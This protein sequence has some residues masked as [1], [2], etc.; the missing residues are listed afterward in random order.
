MTPARGAVTAQSGVLAANLLCLASMLFWA[1][2]LP[3]ANIL[4]PI[5][6]PLP[7][8]ALRLTLA[9][10]VLLPLWWMLDGG[11]VVRGAAWGRGIGV[12][13][14]CL[15]LGATLLI[16][17]QSKTDAVTVAVISALAPI[18]GMGLECLL[19]GR[20]VTGRLVV[21]LMLSLAGGL[22]AYAVAM[23]DLALGLGAAAAL[24]C[25]VAYTWG[26]RA[27][28]TAFPGLSPLGRTAITVTGAAIVTAIAALIHAGFGAASPD[29][30]AFGWPQFGALV[31]FGIG[32]VAISQLLWIMAVGRLGIGMS[33]L[34]INAT[35]FYVM[36]LLFALGGSWSWAQALS[37]AIVGLGVLIAQGLVFPA[38]QGAA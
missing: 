15:G 9:A 14:V 36:L 11:R 8:A 19:D 21:G 28:V 23:G 1:A 31:I 20:R 7:L 30:A 3:A 32:S 29:W 6:P 4:I 18:V 37:A 12:G 24:A 33:S 26:S 25:V 34:H 10:A 16:Y 2:G 13:G 27:T 5:I 38:R 17:A 22:G 35:P